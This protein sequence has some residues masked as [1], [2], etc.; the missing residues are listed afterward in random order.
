MP[1]D[2]DLIAGVIYHDDTP[3]IRPKVHPS[4]LQS[5]F[6]PN[7]I[8]PAARVDQRLLLVTTQPTNSKA[9]VDQQ[10]VLVTTKPTGS[11]ARVDQAFI[12]VITRLENI[13]IDKW[14]MAP[15]Q[16]TPGRRPLQLHHIHYPT[17]IPSGQPVVYVVT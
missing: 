3:V 1:A 13:T 6:G 2:F 17:Y 11:R 12:L 10:F 16:P 9:R 7:T 5:V 15:S 14:F 4:R 8:T